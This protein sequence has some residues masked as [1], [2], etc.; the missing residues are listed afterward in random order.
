MQALLPPHNRA[1]MSSS[2]TQNSLPWETQWLTQRTQQTE[3]SRI[4]DEVLK[5]L[6]YLQRRVL[7]L[8]CRVIEGG[9]LRGGLP[10][11]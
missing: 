2:T 1:A 3:S 4:L 8:L 7:L 10:P 5:P 6:K 11:H 9:D